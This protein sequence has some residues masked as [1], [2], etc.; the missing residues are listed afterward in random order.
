MQGFIRSALRSASMRWPP[1]YK[2]K[3]KARVERGLYRCEGYN[4]EA[5][6]VPASLPPKPGNKRRIDNVLVDHIVPVV[7]P[8][9]GF[10]D[11]DSFIDRLFCDS[12]GL[13]VLCHEC[14]LAK[15]A[16]EKIVRKNA[17]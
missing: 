8:N 13:Q 17:I 11:W 3:S 14:H 15:T 2:V 6:V 4:R 1:K 12:S 5:H 10:V 9:M 16:D 7:C